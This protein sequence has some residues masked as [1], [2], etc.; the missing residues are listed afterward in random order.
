MLYI[1]QLLVT[2][3]L[4]VSL[5][6]SHVN[7]Q[8]HH[9]K[10]YSY[11]FPFLLFFLFLSLSLQFFSHSFDASSHLISFQIY[12]VRWRNLFSYFVADLDNCTIFD[13]R[14]FFQ[15]KL[16]VVLLL[17]GFCYAVA[18]AHPTTDFIFNSFHSVPY[19]YC[20]QKFNVADSSGFI[21]KRFVQVMLQ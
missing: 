18:N 4:F 1:V 10:V 11:R 3:A 16:V 6:N 5:A 7:P 15:L 17:F 21:F 14:D 20:N 13:F 2:T 19:N 12:L 8:F 9:S